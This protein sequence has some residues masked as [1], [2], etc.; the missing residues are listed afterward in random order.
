MSEEL[1]RSQFTFYS[2]FW[3]AVKGLPDEMFV[4]TVKAI[5]TYA[6][7]GIVPELEP[8]PRAIFAVIKPNLDSSRRKA[9]NGKRGGDVKQTESKPQ[10]NG[11]QTVSKTEA[12]GKQGENVSK[13]EKE[14][15]S[16]KESKKEK[17]IENECYISPPLPPSPGG[18]ETRAS[19]RD[20]DFEVFWSAYPRKVGKLDAKRAFGKVRVPVE[21]L[22]TAIEQQ[23]CSDQ[24]T[25][26]NG[27]FIPHPAT[28][29]NRGDW[30]AELPTSKKHRDETIDMEKLQ[31]MID[32]I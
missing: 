30:D 26:D 8:I 24:W 14:K 22:V 32:M 7:D 20:A 28:W 25:R 2:S 10:S 27:Q 15:E 16:K 21:T 12:N 11:K 23:K 3:E 9:E 19:K 1:K 6:L 29:L 31:R 4:P 17:E 18:E 13:K 5:C